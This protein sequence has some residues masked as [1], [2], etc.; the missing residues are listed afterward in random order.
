M[1]MGYHYYNPTPNG[2][3][4]STNVQP[5]TLYVATANTVTI[6]FTTA[7]I[8]PAA[9]KCVI[10]FP[11]TLGGGFSFNSG[12]TS[13]AAFT[14]G[15]SGSLATSITGSVVTLT[16]SG[17]SDI[18]ASTA[19][20]ITLTY[21]LNPPQVGSTGAYEIK[22]TTSA[23]ATIDIDSSV[24]ADQIIEPPATYKTITISGVSMSNVRLI[25]S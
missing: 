23:D 4:T 15:G 21:V 6:S 20:A 14:V 2:T 19:V 17:G 25:P 24:S 7:T 12:G 11:S 10:T 18:A 1:D 3:L 22:T 5:A 8:W 16:R 9:G 13:A